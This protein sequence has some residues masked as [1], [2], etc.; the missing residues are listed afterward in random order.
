MYHSSSLPNKLF[1]TAEGE[2]LDREAQAKSLRLRMYVLCSADSGSV[3]ATIVA[4]W[5]DV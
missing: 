3:D 1:V 5:D 4:S 2:A